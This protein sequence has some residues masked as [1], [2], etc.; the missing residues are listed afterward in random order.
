MRKQLQEELKKE[1]INDD[2]SQINVNI[3][4]DFDFL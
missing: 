2:G 3:N 4:H 1:A